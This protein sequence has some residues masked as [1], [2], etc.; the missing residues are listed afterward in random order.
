MRGVHSIIESG[1]F[2]FGH[3]AR[4]IRISQKLV[5]L[6][7]HTRAKMRHKYARNTFAHSDCDCQ[8]MRFAVT[9][10]VFTHSLSRGISHAK[11]C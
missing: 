7:A 2:S 4:K 8:T 11:L 6:Y 5:L 3:I 9:S 10:C 1:G